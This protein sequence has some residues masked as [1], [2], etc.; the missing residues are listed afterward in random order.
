LIAARIAPFELAPLGTR[1]SDVLVLEV[2]VSPDEPA[3]NAEVSALQLALK[4]LD[5]LL[6]Q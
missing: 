2:H 4:Q 6:D 3:R 5:D 1:N